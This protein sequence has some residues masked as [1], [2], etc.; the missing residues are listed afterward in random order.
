MIREN[1]PGFPSRSDTNLAL[2]PQKMAVG[3]QFQIKKVEGL[4]YLLRSENKGA[5]Q[6][7]GNHTAYLYLGFG[8][9]KKLLF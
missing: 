2:L 7:C 5:D 8:I 6:L 1:R 3:L 4:I 9:C